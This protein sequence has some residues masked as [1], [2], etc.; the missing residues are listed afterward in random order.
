MALTERLYSDPI[1]CVLLSEADAKNDN[2]N[3]HYYDFDGIDISRAKKRLVAYNMHERETLADGVVGKQN[4]EI[5]IWKNVR[6]EEIDGVGR[7][8]VADLY[9]DVSH[10][11]GNQY[12]KRHKNNA[13]LAV[14]IGT[15]SRAM[16][17]RGKNVHVTRCELVE[18][19]VVDIPNFKDSTSLSMEQKNS[20]QDKIKTKDTI[21]LYNGKSLPTLDNK[22]NQKAKTM[23]TQKE[24]ESTQEAKNTESQSVDKPITMTAEQ[25]NSLTAEVKA[26]RESKADTDDK[27]RML[28]EKA[29][30]E[31]KKREEEKKKQKEYAESILNSTF[32]TKE[33]RKPTNNPTP[34]P[35]TN[36]TMNSMDYND[37]INRKGKSADEKAKCLQESMR[38]FAE[39]YKKRDKNPHQAEHI[40]NESLDL[41]KEGKNIVEQCQPGSIPIQNEKKHDDINIELQKIMRRRKS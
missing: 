32:I 14:S 2:S 11:A 9:L 24:S 6:K 27:L 3:G 21:Y 10:P 17:Y 5:G 13:P 18:A 37:L 33:N 4:R 20:L 34:T 39:A 16:E 1:K 28:T 15:D 19:S 29:E 36:N 38:L 30:E 31:R 8:L 26:L 7:A 12:A 41:F 22:S 35:Q 40:L 23:T 25:F